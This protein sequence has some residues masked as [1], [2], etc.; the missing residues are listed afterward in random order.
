MVSERERE[1]GL[2]RGGYLCH[3]GQPRRHSPSPEVRYYGGDRVP[4]RV[5]PYGGDRGV[6]TDVRPRREKAREQVEDRRD[7][8]R[9][10]QRYGGQKLQG[11]SRVRA[12]YGSS[13]WGD[14]SED[15]DD[16]GA[17][18]LSHVGRVS[19]RSGN[20]HDNVVRK[21]RYPSNRARRSFSRTQQ[22]RRRDSVSRA[23]VPVHRRLSKQPERE[24]LLGQQHIQTTGAAPKKGLQPF[25]SQQQQQVTTITHNGTNHNNFVSFYF[26]N[27]PEDISYRSLRQGFEV[28]GIIEDIYLAKKRNVNGVVFGF[29]RYSNVK[30]LDKLLKAVNNIWFGD[31]KV[32]AKVS[33]YDR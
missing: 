5:P 12:W 21:N 13:R 33:V 14:D 31:C 10:E 27:V 1:R 24:V 11:R 22:Q 15:S 23:R 20:I 17:K 3:Q 9:E 30:D 28:C 2:G 18:V 32:V 6:W 29:V 16:Y 26:T 25:S 8:F 7:R 4:S 19:Y